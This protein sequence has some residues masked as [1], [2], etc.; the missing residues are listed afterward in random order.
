MAQCGRGEPEQAAVA[1]LRQAA[2]VMLRQAEQE[3]RRGNGNGVLERPRTVRPRLGRAVVATV[4]STAIK[5][6]IGG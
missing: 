2:V 4:K 6:S 5:A 1:M 3:A